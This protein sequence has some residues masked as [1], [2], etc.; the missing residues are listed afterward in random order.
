M[1]DQVYSERKK[2][3]YSEIVEKIQAMIRNG[4]FKVGEKIPPERTL[5]ETFRVSRNCIRQA[6]QALAEKNILESRQGDGTYVRAVD[7]SLFTSQFALAIQAQKETLRDIIEFRQ[8]LEPQIAWLA[9]KHITAEELDRLKVIVCDQQRKALAGEEDADLDAA[10]HM[11]L[12]LASKNRIIQRVANTV[13]E[14]LNES[15]SESL[16]S[17]ARREASII[18]HFKIIDAMEKKDCEMALQAMKEHLLTVEQLV[19]G[20]DGK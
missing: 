11:Q 5:A 3:L 2:Y 10:F 20:H 1:A 7:Q 15:R 17:D 9:A 19:F 14:I 13:N 12:A 6:V 16:Q 18:G 4:D 8:L